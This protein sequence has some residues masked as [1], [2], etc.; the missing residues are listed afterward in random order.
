MGLIS[1]S[2]TPMFLLECQVF[3]QGH[4]TRVVYDSHLLPPV[5]LLMLCKKIFLLLKSVL[6]SHKKGAEQKGS[7]SNALMYSRVIP[8]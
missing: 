4:L 2:I 1:L 6:T 3:F 7:I 8:E 5:L